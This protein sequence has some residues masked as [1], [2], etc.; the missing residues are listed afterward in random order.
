MCSSGLRNYIIAIAR[1]EEEGNARK[2]LRL[3]AGFGNVSAPQDASQSISMSCTELPA[4]LSSGPEKRLEPIGQF[5]ASLVSTRESD[6]IFEF[7][8]PR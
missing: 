4:G 5:T 8:S 3:R 6:E 7:R 1:Y 2:R